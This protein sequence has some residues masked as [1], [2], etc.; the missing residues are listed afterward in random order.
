MTYN[1]TEYNYSFVGWFLNDTF[2]TDSQE[3]KIKP[4]AFT[5]CTQNNLTIKMYIQ[6]NTTSL[7]GQPWGATNATI[8]YYDATSGAKIN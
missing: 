2:L 8:E 7:A 6:T 3:L 5:G 1:N 4:N